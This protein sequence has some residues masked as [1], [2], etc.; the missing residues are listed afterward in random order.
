MSEGLTTVGFSAF[1]GCNNIEKVIVSNIRKWCNI[2]WE[3]WSNPLSFSGHIYCDSNTEIIDLVIPEGVTKI[4][5]YAFDGCKSLSSITFPESLLEIGFES[6]YNCSDLTSLNIPNNVTFIGASAFAG[7]SCINSL[8]THS[9]LQK[10]DNN[11]FSSCSS[12]KTVTIDSKFG[13]HPENSK[14]G[15]YTFDPS[16]K[17]VFGEQ[18]ENYIIG[19]HL[20]EI[21]SNSFNNCINLKAITIPH[22]IESIGYGAFSGCQNLAVVNIDC[23]KIGQIFY[24]LPSLETIN[25]GNNVKSIEEKAFYK[26]NG[27][28]SL[29][30]PDNVT[31]IGASAFEGNEFLSNITLSNNLTTLENRLFYGCSSLKEINIPTKVGT[32]GNEVFYGCKKLRTLNIPNSVITIGASAFEGNDL[33]ASITLSDNLTTLENRLFYGCSNLKEINM[34]T[35]LNTIGNEVF[36]ECKLLHTLNIPSSLRNIG[37]DAFS[38]CE[39]LSKVIVPDIASWCGIK[40]VT[41]YNWGDQTCS[42]PLSITHHLYS[43]ENTEITDLVIPEGVES[44]NESAFFGASSLKSVSMPRSMKLIGGTAFYECTGLN[45]VIVPDIAAWCGIGFG[46]NPLKYA[47]HLYSDTNTEIADLAI[48]YGVKKINYQ[49][50]QGAEYLKSLSLPNSIETIESSAFFEC[51]SLRSVVLPN[52]LKEIGKGAFQNCSSLETIVIPNSVKEIDEGAFANCLSLYSVTSLIN[53][54]F[55]L[56]NTVFRYYGETY[57]TDV[58]YMAA[59]LY[60]PRGKT[61]M[62]Q[63]TE[64][65]QKFLNMMETD[66]KFKLTYKVDGEVYKTYEIQATEV[67]TPEPDP[68]KEGYIFSGWSNIPYLMPAQ[69]VTVTGSFSIDPGYQ[70]GIGATKTSEAVPE[71][72]YSPEGRRLNALQRG[73]NIIRMSNGTTK[74]VFVK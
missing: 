27:I 48:P 74:K 38:G 55:K 42:N 16:Y 34:P 39:S 35:K 73:I 71:T 24:N 52:G 14:E 66:T 57:N 43:D 40:F 69:D 15:Y 65:W 21:S 11:A 18:V 13:Y 33:L 28:T 54:P 36:G 56:D 63:L 72:Y 31:T 45:K 47:H 10:I 51:R 3:F 19:E 46:D 12:L 59:T 20:T 62:Y 9:Q 44:I 70:A 7:C 67:I 50:F 1:Y 25:I 68:V 58:I 6:F 37:K 22:N 30:I 49:A 41:D 17:E 61:A 8:T 5:K 4:G 53:M 2:D 23:D 29:V 32:I 64:G 60:V 26:C